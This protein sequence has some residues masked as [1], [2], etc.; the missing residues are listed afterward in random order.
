MTMPKLPLPESPTPT[1]TPEKEP[2]S[3]NL[4]EIRK[5][6]YHLATIFIVI[7]PFLMEWKPQWADKIQKAEDVAHEVIKQ[8]PPVPEAPKKVT[9]ES[10]VQEAWAKNK[11]LES[12]KL[13]KYLY[14][15]TQL[16]SASQWK[17]LDELYKSFRDEEVKLGLTDKLKD[18][19]GV[20]RTEWAKQIP[21]IPPSALT[22]P[23]RARIVAF[24]E[25][26]RRILER[27]G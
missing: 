11:D 22:G 19:R 10:T 15:R 27:L 13:L 26:T 4:L 17:D 20:S 7:A 5:D 16:E 6:I 18:L 8:L 25:E 21:E 3:W 24:L 12:L 2:S 14:L 1:A 9:Y 23:L